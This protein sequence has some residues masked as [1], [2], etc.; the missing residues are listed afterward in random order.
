M[1]VGEDLDTLVRARREGMWRR[2]RVH[3]DLRAVEELALRAQLPSGEIRTD[4]HLTLAA[5]TA[6]VERAET[7]F[8]AIAEQ[9]ASAPIR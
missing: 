1:G 5:W 7:S 6:Q 4:L 8:R 2:Q 9:P 3:G